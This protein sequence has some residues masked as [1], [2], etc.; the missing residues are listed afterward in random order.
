MLTQKQEK[1]LSLAEKEQN[2]SKRDELMREFDEM[3]RRE[4]AAQIER[5]LTAFECSLPG[6]LKRHPGRV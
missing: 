5:E 1:L 3:R 2:Q 4:G 6:H